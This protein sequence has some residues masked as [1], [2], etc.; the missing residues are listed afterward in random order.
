VDKWFAAAL[1]VERGR[2]V[3]FQGRPAGRRPSQHAV[4]YI[5][6]RESN[7]VANQIIEAFE[8]GERIRTKCREMVLREFSQ[9]GV[10]VRYAQIFEK[11]LG[12]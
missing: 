3:D 5:T 10:A 1:C 7:S 8:N 4:G 11:A 9:T 6:E 2:L 12:V